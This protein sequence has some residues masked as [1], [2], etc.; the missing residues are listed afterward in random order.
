MNELLGKLVEQN[1]LD[2]AEALNLM[3]YIITHDVSDS[4]KAAFLS[5]LYIKGESPDEISGF[6]E[7]LRNGAKLGRIP[8]LTD[9]VGTGG[10]GKN[11]I[12]VSTAASIVASA[13]GVRVAKHGNS[14]V[15]GKHGS[16]DFM[17]YL[18]YDFSRT[19]LNA[20]RDLIERNYVYIYAPLYN[21]N[22]AKFSAVR[23]KLP[24]R[25]V[26]N[27]LGPLTNPLDPDTMVIGTIDR[28]LS[29]II[30]NVLLEQHKRGFV[31]TS[32]DGMDEI[33]PMEKSCIFSIGEKVTESEF[34]PAEVISENISLEDITADDPATSFTMTLDG[35]AGKNLKVAQF[36]ALNTAPA[37][38]ANG[39]SGSIETGYDAAMKCIESGKA[40]NQVRKI[41]GEEALAEIGL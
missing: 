7:A 30:A 25:T 16:A 18:G 31:V 19:G 13:L 39:L 26:F 41:S 27:F 32:S 14:A 37:I 11:T 10:D 28:N 38:V 34:Y 20:E 24:F 17:K 36:I 5:S 2:R 9:I 21:S 6:A 3:N 22:F 29:R 12:N 4:F 8:G 1:D 23:K 40:L 33:S 15:T 35:L